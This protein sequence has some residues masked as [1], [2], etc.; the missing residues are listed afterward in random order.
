MQCS[1][2]ETSLTSPSSPAKT[3]P[4]SGPVGAPGGAARTTG[5]AGPVGLAGASP[6]AASPQLPSG[7]EQVTDQS[8]RRY[9]WNR[10]TGETRWKRPSFSQNAAS[11]QTPAAAP[12]AAAPQLPAGCEK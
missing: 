8:G 7:W 9:Y 6:A 4:A 3:G 12:T 11:G 5:G 2:G 1:I 10:S